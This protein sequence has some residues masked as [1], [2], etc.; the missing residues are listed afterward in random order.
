MYNFIQISKIN[1][2]LFCP[3][4]LYFH[5]VYENFGELSYKS[6]D[7]V[8]GS[9]AHE[10]VDKSEYSS[11]VR[12]KQG[13]EVCSYAYGI[14]GKIDVYDAEKKCLI[15]RKKSV[16]RIFDGYIMQLLAQKICLEEMGFTVD[17]IKIHSLDDN[18]RYTLEI[19]D[20]HKELFK[21]T[22]DSIRSFDITKATHFQDVQKCNRC[23]YNELCRK[24]I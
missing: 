17:A 12:Y 3:R 2:F 4:S 1:D 22:I 7:Q 13:V 15:E 20:K 14:V 23:I 21:E 16:K 18:K 6:K 9:I 5:S 8:S 11:R 19:T 24:N 10:K